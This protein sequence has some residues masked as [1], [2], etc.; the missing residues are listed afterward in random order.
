MQLA[1]PTVCLQGEGQTI[2]LIE[3]NMTNVSDQSNYTDWKGWL[4]SSFCQFSKYQKE[5]LDAEILPNLSSST[6]ATIL[7]IGY[8]NGIFLGWCLSKKYHIMGVE[9]IPELI[10]RAKESGIPAYDSIYSQELSNSVSNF[11]LIVA[12]DVL[13]HIPD[14][15]LSHF[16]KRIEEL[17]KEGG[18]FVFRIPNG[19]SPFGLPYQ[20]G[21]LTH[22]SSIGKNKIEQL[23]NEAGLI[24]EKIEPPAKSETKLISLGRYLFEIM[25]AYLYFEGRRYGLSPNVVAVLTKTK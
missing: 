16:V 8:G 13:E 22:C 25:I 7:E 4:K 20:N 12:F 6:T 5:Y 3:N 1:L 18:K 21:D 2:W 14:S 10:R 17:L 11:D 23:A 19:D 15:E 9:V 24:V